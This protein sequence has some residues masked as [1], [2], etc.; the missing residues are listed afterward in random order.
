M[1]GHEAEG[2][3][4]LA[5]AAGADGLRHAEPLAEGRGDDPGAQNE[6]QAAQGRGHHV[7]GA[8]HLRTAVGPE[9]GD[10]PVLR[11]VGEPVE[12][13]VYAQQ[14]HPP[15]GAARIGRGRAG[16][17]PFARVQRE[18]GDAG[19]HGGHHGV[20][21]QRIPAAEE[22]DVQEHDGNQLAALCERVGDVVDVRQSGV[23][24]GCGERL[25]QRDE[26][27]RGYDAAG[28]DDTRDGLAGGRRRVEVQ[29]ARCRREE[30]L[31]DLEED[32][33]LPFLGDARVRVGVRGRQDLLLEESP[34]EAGPGKTRRGCQPALVV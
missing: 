32:G 2:G 28:R 15:R 12:E 17:A 7:V 25:A 16:L 22:G 8:H 10:D 27:E 5:A 3:A 1:A 4:E 30:G 18:D 11:A 31:D 9:L 20:L 14:E 33:E 19:R 24:Y 29:E 6:V 26:Q 34:G 13:Q 21:V 23:A